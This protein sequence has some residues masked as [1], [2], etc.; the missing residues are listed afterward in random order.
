MVRLDVLLVVKCNVK[1][2]DVIVA[3]DGMFNGARLKTAYPRWVVLP[4][5]VPLA[6]LPTS[7]LSSLLL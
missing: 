6:V 4:F 5:S 7:I 1:V 2:T 3:V